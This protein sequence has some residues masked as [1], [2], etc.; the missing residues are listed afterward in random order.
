MSSPLRVSAGR[1]VVIDSS[2]AFKWFDTSEPGADIAGSLLREHQRDD[3]ALLAPALLLPEVVNALLSRRT[4]VEDIERAI[5]FLAD[6]DLLIAPLDA[7]LL[8]HAVQIASAE[9]LALYDATFIALAALLDADL[10]TADRRQATTDSC[11]VLFVGND[12]EV[13]AAER[14]AE[15]ALNNAVTATEY[16]QALS[17][18]RARGID[19]EAVPHQ[20]RP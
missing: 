17:D 11:R 12:P 3:V 6:V 18:V 20:S 7:G 9:G 4:P 14:M 10:V 5:G 13:Y 8:A 1:P 15:F 2:V 16:D 19:P